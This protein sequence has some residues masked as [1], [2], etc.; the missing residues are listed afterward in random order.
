VREQV[1]ALEDHADLLALQGDVLLLVL[2]QLRGASRLAKARPT[3]GS[4]AMGRRIRPAA[5]TSR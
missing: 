1:E 3:M 5:A 4:F 2:D